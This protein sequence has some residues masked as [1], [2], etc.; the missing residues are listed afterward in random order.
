MTEPITM[1]IYKRG[2]GE[3][4]DD[5]A[6]VVDI[7]P[8]LDELDDET[9]VIEEVWE[10]KSSRA[11]S[12]SCHDCEEPAK[13]WGLCETHAREDDPEY[14]QVGDMW[15]VEDRAIYHKKDE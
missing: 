10:L 7:D 4:W 6:R 9:E 12:R 14:F 5:F 3:L 1:K 13:H 11:F 2:D 8:Y 15:V